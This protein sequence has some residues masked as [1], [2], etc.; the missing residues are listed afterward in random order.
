MPKH[1]LY[2][3]RKR[4]ISYHDQRGVVF[5]VAALECWMR[6]T[7]AKFGSDPIG[8]PHMSTVP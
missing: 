4:G 2:A 5:Y 3:A 8:A 1:S 7:W 6:L